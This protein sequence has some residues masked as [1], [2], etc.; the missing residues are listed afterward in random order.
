[1][2]QIAAKAESQRPLPDH[3]EMLFDYSLM[4]LE[5]EKNWVEKVIQK[6]EDEPSEKKSK[7]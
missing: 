4:T 1:M 5:F 3:V 6:M 7:N 2:E